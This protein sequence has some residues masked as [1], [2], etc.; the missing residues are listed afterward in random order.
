MP[1]HRF[2]PFAEVLL[3][4]LDD[5]ETQRTLGGKVVTRSVRLKAVGGLASASDRRRARQTSNLASQGA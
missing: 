3:S 1:N 2:R 4:V 5:I